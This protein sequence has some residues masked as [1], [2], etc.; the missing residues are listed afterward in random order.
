M[1]IVFEINNK[2]TYAVTEEKLR[3]VIEKTIEAAKVQCLKNKSVE[4]SLAMVGEAE[5]ER[6]NLNYRKKNHPTDVLSFCEYESLQQIC[7][8]KSENIFLGELIICPDDISKKAVEMEVTFESEMVHIVAHGVLHL[9]GFEHGEK[10]FT[11]QEG[12]AENVEI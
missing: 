2:T 8:E 5:I 4:L 11:I 7:E 1:K 9:L 6:L 10:M 3:V 12:I